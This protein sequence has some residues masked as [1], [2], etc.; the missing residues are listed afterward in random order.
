[1]KIFI[2][3]AK[4]TDLNK[5]K[6]AVKIIK[7]ACPTAHVYLVSKVKADWEIVWSLELDGL[8]EKIITIM[9]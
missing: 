4:C 8:V 1:M 3:D 7:D 9:S 2:E 5:I 6:T